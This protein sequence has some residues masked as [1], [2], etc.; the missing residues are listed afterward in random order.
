M[1]TS[2]PAPSA[3]ATT[4]PP[5]EKK[6]RARRTPGERAQINLDR[7][8]ARLQRA[9]DAQEAADAAL[10]DAQAVKRAADA[11]VPAAEKALAWASKHPDLPKKSTVGGAS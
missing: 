6:P 2:T 11:E 4:P 5:A 9:R 1:T 10:K 8:V 7:T 3:A